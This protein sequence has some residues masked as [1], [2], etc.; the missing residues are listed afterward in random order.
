MCSALALLQSLRMVPGSHSGRGFDGGLPPLSSI[1]RPPMG[2]LF[3]DLWVEAGWAPDRR[4]P[5]PP[6]L[7][8]PSLP[9]ATPWAEQAAIWLQQSEARLEVT[10][11]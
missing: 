10:A 7:T 1:L 11:I 6:W 8:E 5:Q 3:C 4:V 9:P 2:A